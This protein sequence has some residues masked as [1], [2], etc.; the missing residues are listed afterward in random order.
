M[1]FSVEHI[2]LPARD[3][4]ALR[5]WYVTKLGAKCIAPT[6]AEPPFF[7]QPPGATA[8]FEIYRASGANAATEDNGLAGWRHLA[9]R[10]ESIEAARQVLEARGVK[11]LDPIKPA[12]GGG[13]VLFFQDGE[14]NLLHLVDRPADSAVR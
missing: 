3:A 1:N 6:G 5:D 7:L 9:L 4:A 14:G 11:F 8:S 2:G 12:A 13:R 10:V